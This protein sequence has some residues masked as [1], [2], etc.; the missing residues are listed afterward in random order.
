MHIHNLS[1]N[2]LNTLLNAKRDF[3]NNEEL[4][5]AFI[6]AILTQ[7][8]ILAVEVLEYVRGDAKRC[9]T[10]DGSIRYI[11]KAAYL[12]VEKA[13]QRNKIEAIKAIRAHTGASLKGAKDFCEAEWPQYFP[14]L[15]RM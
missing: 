11:N 1:I 6:D 9:I 3:Y 15:P 8:P 5:E 2:H 4:Q 13:A 12:E 14:T 7:Y 10:I